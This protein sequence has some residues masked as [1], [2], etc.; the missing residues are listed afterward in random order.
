MPAND[1]LHGQ[2]VM[3]D[4]SHG[5]YRLPPSILNTAVIG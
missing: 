4:D 2:P 1:K 3:P 5:I